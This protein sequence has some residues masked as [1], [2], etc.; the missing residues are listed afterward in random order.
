MTFR[1]AVSHLLV[2]EGLLALAIS[3]LEDGELNS[4]GFSNPWNTSRFIHKAV[5]KDGEF[6]TV[7]LLSPRPRCRSASSQTPF[8]VLSFI[9]TDLKVRGYS[10]SASRLVRRL[11]FVCIFDGWADLICALFKVWFL[12]CFA[13]LRQ[14]LTANGCC[15]VGWNSATEL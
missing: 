1:D 7:G 13:L 14:W 3:R 5:C 12:V 9:S 8:P 2:S 6:N 4:R 15:F 10:L 11:V